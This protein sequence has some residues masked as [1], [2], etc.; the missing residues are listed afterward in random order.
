MT[1]PVKVKLP[2]FDGMF[3]PQDDDVPST[4]ASLVASNV[5]GDR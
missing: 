3:E 4:A 1:P 5:I 2:H